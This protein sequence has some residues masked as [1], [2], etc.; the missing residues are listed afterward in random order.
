MNEPFDKAFDYMI[1][2]EGGF[3]NHASDRGGATK[4]GITKGT[5]ERWKGHPVSVEEVRSLLLDEA[6][7]IYK[8]WYWDTNSLDGVHSTPIATCVFDIGVVCGTGSAGKFAQQ[9]A[10]SHGAGQLVPDGVI[11]PKSLAAI[12]SMDAG[13]FIRA[14]ADRVGAYFRGIVNSRPDQGVFLA[15]WMNR[16]NRL[17][18]LI[19]K[20]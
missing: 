4:Y 5:L 6:K 8:A 2:N 3:S 14:F 9:V 13:V 10:N 15:G 19:P 1:V 11:G 16:A 18:T 20:N 7:A 17:L 12:N